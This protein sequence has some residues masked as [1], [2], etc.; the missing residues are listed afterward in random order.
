MKVL[1]VFDSVSATKMTEKVAKAIA[2]AMKDQ[3]ADVDCLLY[4]DVSLKPSRG[5]TAW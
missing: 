4:K 1:V 5:T 2:A 3:G